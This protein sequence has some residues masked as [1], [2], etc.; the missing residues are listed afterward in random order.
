MFLDNCNIFLTNSKNNNNTDT[1]P[2][3]PTATITSNTIA[4]KTTAITLPI[5]ELL[6]PLFS[7]V[8]D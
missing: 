3:I 4:I 1:S 7:L 5:L 8:H 6:L 2:N